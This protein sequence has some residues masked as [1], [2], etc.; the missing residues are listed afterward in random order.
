MHMRMWSSGPY[1]ILHF[2]QQLA[3]AD[4]KLSILQLQLWKTSHT[5]IGRFGTSDVT[6]TSDALQITPDFTP[7]I[8][9]IWTTSPQGTSESVL[10]PRR[11]GIL[12]LEFLTLPVRSSPPS[13]RWE[14]AVGVLRTSYNSWSR[15]WR[16]QGSARS[17]SLPAVNSV[18]QFHF[19]CHMMLNNNHGM[20]C[21]SDSD[22]GNRDN[23]QLSS[24]HLMNGTQKA[25][26]NL[27]QKANEHIIN[28]IMWQADRS[29]LMETIVYPNP[30]QQ[31]IE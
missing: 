12:V 17:P 7:D 27:T 24:H 3:L 15:G 19:W 13:Q 2:P 25:L 20:S 14:D 1:Q 21:D 18:L 30:I 6:D 5:L 16:R 8:W 23:N 11:I 28:A 29:G 4:F 22:T 26:G 9:S 31:K 10:K